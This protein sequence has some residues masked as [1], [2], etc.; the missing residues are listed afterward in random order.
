MK[1][2]TI[3]LKDEIM[4]FY[5]LYLR[6][7]KRRQAFVF[8]LNENKKIAFENIELLHED[9]TNIN[10]FDSKI[11]YFK[12]HHQNLQYCEIIFTEQPYED[13]VIPNPL[14]KDLFDEY[15]LK[16]SY[17]YFSHIEDLR[18]IIL[19]YK[20][21]TL[22]R[23]NRADALKRLNNNYKY[24]FTKT[25]FMFVDFVL[26]APKEVMWTVK[27]FIEF[28]NNDYASKY[29][30]FKEPIKINDISREALKENRKSYK[31]GLISE[32]ISALGMYVE[33]ETNFTNI[34][35][36]NSSLITEFLRKKYSK[37]NF[38]GKKRIIL[39]CPE[40]IDNFYLNITSGDK[41]ELHVLIGALNE[42]LG[43]NLYHILNDVSLVTEKVFYHELGHAIFAQ[44]DQ[45]NL[46][47]PNKKEFH[48][49][50]LMSSFKNSL[51][52]DALL[53]LMTRFQPSHYRPTY[54]RDT[55]FDKIYD[56]KS[57]KSKLTLYENNRVEKSTQNYPDILIETF[58]DDIDESLE[59]DMFFIQ[60]TKK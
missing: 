59:F 58:N 42:A 46:C 10:Q 21:L 31:E 55:V 3:I 14:Y 56:Y 52:H 57:E 19:Q 28:N 37:Y 25:N 11:Y 20:N 16:K 49:N 2:L 23:P 36:S 1:E 27:K 9:I 22:K 53:L 18:D 6:V 13:I 4:H 54:I 50:Y 51:N 29:D 60:I 33:L 38:E 12:S 26:D 40:L 35:N 15:I 39:I 34:N 32:A 17:D 41:L 48:A 24:D 47:D 30:R 43:V 5:E 8:S 44:Y 7:F 45:E